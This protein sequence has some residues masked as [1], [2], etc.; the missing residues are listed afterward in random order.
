VLVYPRVPG[1]D[2]FDASLFDVAQK[3][4]GR[5]SFSKQKGTCEFIF[6]G[7]TVSLG[8]CVLTSLPGAE[9]AVGIIDQVPG[10]RFNGTLAIVIPTAHPSLGRLDILLT[11]SKDISEMMEITRALSFQRE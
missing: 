8:E 5:I 9:A 11:G 7:S 1:K 10:V 2:A 3:P 4:T 6:A